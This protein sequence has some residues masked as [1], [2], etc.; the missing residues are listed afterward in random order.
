M[1]LAGV[2]ADQ[3]QKKGKIVAA[4]RLLD[5]LLSCAKANPN[6][7]ALQQ[8]SAELKGQPEFNKQLEE[9]KK[10]N[11]EGQKLS[12]ELGAQIMTQDLKWWSATVSDLNNKGKGNTPTACMYRRV[13]NFLGLISYM[14][15]T[16]YMQGGDLAHADNT[17]KIFRMLDPQN[18]DGWYLEAVYDLKRNDAAAALQA[19]KKCADAGYNQPADILADADLAPVRNSPEFAAIIAQVRAN[20]MEAKTQ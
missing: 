3:L 16:R 7:A 9:E 8:K 5:G 4:V 17:R 10:A 6:N 11:A 13:T 12:Q 15:T 18:P 1:Q 2:Y 20:Y 19:L 14:A